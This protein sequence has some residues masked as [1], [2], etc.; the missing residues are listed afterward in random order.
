MTFLQE[1]K[2]GVGGSDVAAIIGISK[3]ATPLD[4]F[5]RKTGRA[6]EQEE[7]PAMYWGTTLEAVVADEFA[8]RTGWK[9]ERCETIRREWRIANLDRVVTLPDGSKAVL[10]CK[11]ANAYSDMAYGESQEE[12]ILLGIKLEPAII[13]DYYQTQVQWYLHLTGYQKAYL[14]V[15]IGGQ[16]YRIFE[17]ARDDDLIQKLDE[18]CE[19][20]W[21]NHVLK[22]IP[23]EP[24]CASDAERLYAG[25]QKEQD[26]L[27][28]ADNE[29]ATLI[30]EYTTAQLQSRALD[31]QMEAIKEKLIG[32]LGDRKGLAIAGK[33]AVSFVISEYNKFN[34][35]KFKKEHADL[36]E[37]YQEPTTR[38]LFRVY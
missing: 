4:I 10:E 12:G 29:A 30:A 13:P 20:F 5:E 21:V 37:Q 6:P 17:I 22:D 33:K 11:T 16:D 24:I 25:K 7:T 19:D 35:A 27:D 9:V 36:Y 26:P 14:A 15:L 18:A 31:K 23:P 38:S 34:S 2:N 32:I 3:W 1:R 28:E 8:K